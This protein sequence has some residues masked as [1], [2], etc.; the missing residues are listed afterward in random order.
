MKNIFIVLETGS[1]AGGVRVVGEIANR[2]AEKP[3]KYKVYIFSVNPKETMT[4]WFRLDSRVDWVS[5]FKTGTTQDYDELA[6][7][8]KKNDGY[9]MAT[10][11]RTCYAVN[12][13]SKSGEGV[14]L[15][16][17]IESVYVHGPIVTQAVMDTYAM[18]LR[19][20]TTSRWVEKNLTDT[21]Y[22]G[23]GLSNFYRAPKKPQRVPVPL[24]IG[25]KQ[26]LKGWT[27]LCEVARYLNMGGLVL[28]TFGLDTHLPMFAK[29]AHLG[30][31]YNDKGRKV[32]I[33]DEQVRGLYRRA[34][35]FIS[36]SRHEG[37]NLTCLEAMS[38]GCPVVKTRDDGSDEYVEDGVNC[39]I[40]NSPSEIADLS[41]QVLKDKGLS[42]K[43]SSGGSGVGMRYRW[44]EVMSRF[45]SILT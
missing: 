7:V 16:Q 5:F 6:A 12:E 28:N 26:A 14:Y 41:I 19:K 15:V 22:I 27:E 45:E 40:G 17:D 30:A 33:T 31:K 10:Y 38:C 37:L 25:R 29:H 13:A 21:E 11:W 32:N 43:L 35:V 8:L 18:P 34:G 3:D 39:L 24:A 42:S 4:D 36:T 1:L 2:L 23:I 9:K 44:S 20:I